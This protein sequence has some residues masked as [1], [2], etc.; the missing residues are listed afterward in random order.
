MNDSDGDH[1]GDFKDNYTKVL[2]AV[3]SLGATAIWISPHYPSEDPVPR[4]G[5]GRNAHR[6][7]A[8][9]YLN[10]DPLLGTLTNLQNLVTTHIIKG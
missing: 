4:T 6:Y 8:K 5:Y 9:D 10:V 1:Y 2:D 3:S 7:D